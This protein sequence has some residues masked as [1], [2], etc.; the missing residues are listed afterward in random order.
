[1]IDT[2]LAQLPKTVCLGGC[3]KVV[4]CNNI[5]IMKYGFVLTTFL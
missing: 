5:K 2:T 3:A 4:S 1:M